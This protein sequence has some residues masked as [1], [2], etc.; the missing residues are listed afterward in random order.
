MRPEEAV[1]RHA[2]WL[3]RLALVLAAGVLYAY[4]VSTLV[5]DP[6]IRALWGGFYGIVTLPIWLP[7]MVETI[8]Q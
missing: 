3:T 4:V 8:F 2:A 7:R 5:D 6:N 1:R